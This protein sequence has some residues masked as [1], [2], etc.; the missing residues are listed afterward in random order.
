M[1]EDAIYYTVMNDYENY[2][3]KSTK[4]N[5]TNKNNNKKV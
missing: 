2:T 5:G 1:Q 3:V 4:Y